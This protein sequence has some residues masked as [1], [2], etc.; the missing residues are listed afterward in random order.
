MPAAT[1]QEPLE[2][3]LELSAE[4]PPPRKRFTRAE[5]EQ[6]L[7]AGLSMIER[8]EL[9]DGD[10]IDKMGQNPPHAAAIRRTAVAFTEIFGA[11][12]ILVQA[13]IEVAAGDQ[14]W[15]WPEPDVAVLAQ[16]SPEYDQRHPRGDELLVLV[17]VA[18]TTVRQ[19]AFKK[20]DIYARAGVPEYWVL[21]IRQRRLIVHRHLARG[22]YGE[23]LVLAETEEVSLGSH[24]IPVVGLLPGVP[25]QP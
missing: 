22:S 3:I 1:L 10:L 7:E 19:D 12:R 23:A 6:M 4:P 11:D 21:A 14:K 5:V 17:E 2:E 16:S 20:R 25:E 24:S 13:P 9:I 18:D 8:C 15:T